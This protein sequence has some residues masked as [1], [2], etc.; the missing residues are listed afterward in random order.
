MVMGSFTGR[1]TLPVLLRAMIQGC[2]Q[3][4]GSLSSLRAAKL[5]KAPRPDSAPA[6]DLFCL[7]QSVMHSLLHYGSCSLKSIQFFNGWKDFFI[8]ISS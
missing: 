6:A 8:V 3:A 5:L 4:R 2:R 7:Y 1:K